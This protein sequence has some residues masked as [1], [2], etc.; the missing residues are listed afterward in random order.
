MNILLLLSLSPFSPHQHG[1][2]PP[3]ACKNIP[4]ARCSGPNVSAPIF[5]GFLEVLSPCNSAPVDTFE[6]SLSKA[7][8]PCIVR[9]RHL[10][11]LNVNRMPLGSLGLSL[12]AKYALQTHLACKIV[13]QVPRHGSRM[14]T[15]TLKRGLWR[16]DILHRHLATLSSQ[17][18]LPLT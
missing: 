7:P 10:D 1:L 4:R 9:T 2:C 8:T 16:V 18:T 6:G 5:P 13:P 12:S 17:G 11:T 15:P 3:S 14:C